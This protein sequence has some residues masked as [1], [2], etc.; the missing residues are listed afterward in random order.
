MKYAGKKLLSMLITLFGVS[1]LVFLAFDLIPG[2]PALSQLGTQA[3]PE[4]LEA[5]REE[6]GLNEPF[7]LRYFKWIAA[8]CTGDFGM[9]YSYHMSVG[10]MILEKLPISIC[11]TLMAFIM[12]LLLSIP[13]GLLSAKHEGGKLDTVICACNQVLMSV[14]PFFSGILITLLFGIVL[15]WFTPGGF[16]SANQNIGAFLGYLFF[17]ALAIALPKA[18]M[19]VKMLRSSLVTELN[20]DYPRTAF[21]RGNTKNQVLLGHVLKN[22]LIPV[23]TFFGMALTDILTGSIIVE[24]VFNIPG[25]GRILLTSIMNRDYPVVEAIIMLMATVVIVV[26]FLVDLL[27]QKLD[28]QITVE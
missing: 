28:P 15:K 18:A 19:A 25:L 1:F 13:L 26:N 2:D 23:L 8:F 14:P 9:S 12:V 16:V 24:Q 6:M 22:A 4:R 27:Y 10:D 17:P 7:F 20:K 21:S 11:M 5:L 3:T